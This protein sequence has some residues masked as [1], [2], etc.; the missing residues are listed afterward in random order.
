MSSVAAIINFN[1]PQFVAEQVS[2]IKQFLKP[3]VVIVFDNSTKLL[4]TFE[5]KEAANNYGAYYSHTPATDGDASRH[6]AEALNYAYAA[7]REKYDI[8]ALFD[9]DV[10]PFKESRIFEIAQSYDFCGLKQI[11]GGK[12]YLHPGYLFINTKLVAED[13]DFMP[14]PGMDTGGQLHE[15]IKEKEVLSLSY[16]YEPELGYEIINGSMM[17]FVKGSN[18]QGMDKDLHEQRIKKLFDRLR[19]LTA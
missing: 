19:G 16:E 7:L 3:D 8:V 17:H 1:S 14:I 10:F 4:A 15:L 6:H 2:R 12:E 13:L 9:H 11:A 5:I 18:W